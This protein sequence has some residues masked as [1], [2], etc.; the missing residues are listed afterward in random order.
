MTIST[1]TP[2]VQYAG[3]GSTTAF[4]V[5]FEYI[6]AAG[7]TVIFTDASGNDTTWVKDTHFTL[8]D[9]NVAATGTVNVKTSPTD[10]TPA[11][12]TKLT[13]LRDEPLTQGQSYTENDPFPAKS[14]EKALDRLTMQVQM[15]SER[16]GRAILF[17]ATGGTSDKS[18]APIGEG[19]FWLADANGNMVDGG[20]AADIADAEENA[21]AAANSASDAAD[22]ATDSATSAAAAAASAAG[23]NLPALTSDDAGKVLTVKPDGSG[24]EASR[25]GWIMAHEDFGAD[26]TGA[27]S[28]VAAI[29]NALDYAGSVGKPVYLTAGTYKIDEQIVMPVLGGGTSGEKPVSMIGD[30]FGNIGWGNT[31]LSLTGDGEIVFD[32]LT[33]IAQAG[34]LSNMVINGN[35]SATRGVYFRLCRFPFLERVNI[36]NFAGAGAVFEGCIMSSIRRSLIGGCGSATE[37]QIVFDSALNGGVRWAGTTALLDQMYISGGN[38]N[39]TC[40]LMI[41][42]T[43][44]VV[45]MGGAIESTGVM[46]RASSKTGRTAGVQSVI[47]HGTDFENPG[48]GNPYIEI[49]NGWNG[50]AGAAGGNWDIRGCDFSASGTTSTPY[51]I[52]LNHTNGIRVG[53]LAAL[54]APGTPTAIFYLDGSDN[55]G[56]QV[57]AMRP[58]NFPSA[59][60]VM[61]N[62]AM[63]VD[64]YPWLPFNQADRNGPIRTSA[65]AIAGTS[66]TIKGSGNAG[67]YYRVYT[68]VNSVATTMTKLTDG[69]IGMEIML[70]AS[71]GNTT[72]QQG[73]SADQFSLLSGA[74][75]A[76]TAGKPYGFWHNGTCW[77]QQF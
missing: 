75:T 6:L 48:N 51:I 10:Y 52:Y 38:T 42:D 29:Q 77:V 45:I 23:V 2:R 76:M 22:S 30:G 49:G 14:H 57:E 33:N 3:N 64:A 71:N 13:I 16:I 67:G 61:E 34:G 40:G 58:L 12:G 62:G 44:G 28:A 69:M 41:D 39:T 43:Q 8:A 19:H 68:I 59:P 1:Q 21:A 32:G 36:R 15:L 74:D 18:I 50:G 7:V 66:P 37:G 60:W 56:F 4:P 20:S 27:T 46:I 24:F 9:N 73:T 47:V 53:V 65:R 11:S 54:A 70:I 5:P 35:S 17:G 26:N 55:Y 72:L 31:I 63:R 25:R